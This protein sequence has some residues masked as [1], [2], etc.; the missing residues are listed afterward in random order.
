MNCKSDGPTRPGGQGQ[1][2]GV[3]LHPDR[4]RQ[5][6]RG[7]GLAP[8]TLQHLQ[9]L[10]PTARALLWLPTLWIMPCSKWPNDSNSSLAYDCEP[11]LQLNEGVAM[12]L[13]TVKIC[14]SMAKHELLLVF[15]HVKYQWSI[16]VCRQGP[17]RFLAKSAHFHAMHYSDLTGGQAGWGWGIQ[18]NVS[19]LVLR[20]TRGERHSF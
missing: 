14:I 8:D 17:P 12:H 10:G 11:S 7:R 16:E 19:S 20:Q 15:L 2:P 9:T 4:G 3:W 1:V 13:D 5:V 6:V 18:A